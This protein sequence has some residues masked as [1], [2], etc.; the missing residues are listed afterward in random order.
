MKVWLTE[1][2]SAFD[3]SR[4]GSQSGRMSIR[5][6]LEAAAQEVDNF[7]CWNCDE[8]V[9]GAPL[10]LEIDAPEGTIPLDSAVYEAIEK[11][12]GL[13]FVRVD[14]ADYEMKE[15]EKEEKK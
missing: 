4:L 1:F 5:D 9:D 10:E 13:L 12:F 15:D 14:W 2:T 3:A 6:E 8:T 11:M 7:E